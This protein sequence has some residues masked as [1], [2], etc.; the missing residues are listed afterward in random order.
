MR[1]A[2][3][4]IFFAF[5]VQYQ[6]NVKYKYFQTRAQRLNNQV[7][8]VRITYSLEIKLKVKCTLPQNKKTRYFFMPIQSK[9]N[10]E[11]RGIIHAI[12]KA[13]NRL[14]ICVVE[15]IRD[16]PKLTQILGEETVDRM[17]Q[18]WRNISPVKNKNLYRIIS[19]ATVRFG[20]IV[21]KRSRGY[22]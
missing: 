10:L 13:D 2:C 9:L 11:H 16:K 18:S 12:S 14:S 7:V 19:R 20:N 22:S 17:L 15:D 5:V 4:Y 8:H 21:T 6:N 1:L 3:L